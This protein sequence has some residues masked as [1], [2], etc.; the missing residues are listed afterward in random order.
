MSILTHGRKVFEDNHKWYHVDYV[1]RREVV[2]LATWR[3][4]VKM[5]AWRGRDPWGS[6]VIK[7]AV[8]R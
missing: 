3:E 5:V 8:V 1:C 2:E 7:K 6:P 4:V